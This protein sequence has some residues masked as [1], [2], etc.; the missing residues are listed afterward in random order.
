VSAKGTF[1]LMSRLERAA[2]TA[3]SDAAACETVRSSFVALL[4]E[5]GAAAAPFVAKLL[6]GGLGADAA[7]IGWTVVARGIVI[8]GEESSNP[9]RASFAAY[10]MFRGRLDILRQVVAQVPLDS[11]PPEVRPADRSQLLDLLCTTKSEREHPSFEGMDG[12]PGLVGVAAANAK[13]C[14]YA[15]EALL[16]TWEVNPEHCGFEDLS[17][18]ASQEGAFV[19]SFLMNKGIE[20]AAAPAPEVALQ[21]SRARPSRR[22]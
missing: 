19:R 20:L 10:C 3:G 11:V 4:K 22:V 12:F 5:D 14:G 1:Q 6:G 15:N 7:L 17:E 21:P 8:A 16:L 18:E 9:V 2:A 13:D